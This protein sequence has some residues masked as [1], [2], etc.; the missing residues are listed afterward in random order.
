MYHH[1]APDAPLAQGEIIDHCPILTWL[2]DQGGWNV[3]ES[4]E[5]VIVLT[6]ACD[7][8]NQKTKRIQVALVHDA[9]KLVDAGFLTA[10]MIA[11]HVRRHLVYGWYFLP[12]DD[13]FP[14]SIVDLRDLHTM[15]RALLLELARG[16]KRVL[17]LSTPYREHLSQHFSV[18]FSRI[19][20]P[21]PYG[22]K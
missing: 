8:E 4:T 9:L 6:Q 5:R 1:L 22:T 19:G 21:E 15:P 2:S 12:G 18:T 17:A 16:G 14:E 13:G 11:D 20:L 3:N 7:L 10:R